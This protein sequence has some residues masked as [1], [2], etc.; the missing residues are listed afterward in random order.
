LKNGKSLNKFYGL[1]AAHALYRENGVWYHALKEFPGILFDAGG[2]IRF[3]S[4]QEYQACKG[5]KKGPDPNHI[6]VAGGI[7]TLTAYKVL[8]PRPAKLDL[9]S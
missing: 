9:T 5:I 7:Q 8:S 2:Y 4:K 1:D 3:G 6:H